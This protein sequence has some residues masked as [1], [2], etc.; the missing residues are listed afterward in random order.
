MTHH[1]ITPDTPPD[2]TY[3]EAKIWLRTR[4]CTIGTLAGKTKYGAAIEL[5]NGD[6]YDPDAYW[7][8]RDVAIDSAEDRIRRLTSNAACVKEDAGSKEQG[9]QSAERTAHVSV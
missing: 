4:V 1:D 6:S 5:E 7:L 3:G 2:A 8:S 9:E